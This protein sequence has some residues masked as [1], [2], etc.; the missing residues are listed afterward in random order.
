MGDGYRPATGGQ[1]CRAGEYARSAPA[2]SASRC[3][4]CPPR[5]TSRCGSGS[6]ISNRWSTPFD[7]IEDLVQRGEVDLGLLIHE[8]QLTYADDGFKLWADMGEWWLA[9]TGLP[10]PLGGNV[11]APRPRA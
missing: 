10:L 7:Q 9:E 5:R 1:E 8:G 11:V 3:P 4:A 2:E 6:R